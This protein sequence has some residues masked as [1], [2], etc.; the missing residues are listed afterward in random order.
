MCACLC[1][2]VHVAVVLSPHAPL[3][4][5]RCFERGT[6]SV[7]GSI[8]L[9]TITPPPVSSLFSLF[10]FTLTPSL[11]TDRANMESAEERDGEREGGREGGG[12]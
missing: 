8:P 6:R 4:H 5:V 7:Q 10:L 9:P 1:V 11:T 3:R 2:C 12:E